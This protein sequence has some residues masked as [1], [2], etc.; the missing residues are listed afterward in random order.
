MFGTGSD[1]ATRISIKDGTGIANVVGRYGSLTFQA[2]VDGA[3]SGSLINFAIDGSEKVRIT[4]DGF[5]GIGVTN[6]ED[7]DS[8]A[9]NL[10]VGSTGQEGITIRSSSPNTGN[11]FFNDGLNL[12]AGISFKHDSTASSRYFSFS[13]NNG[14]SFTEQLRI[15]DGKLIFSNDQN[16]YITGGS[17][18]FRF[19]TGGTERVRINASGHV[20]LPDAAELQFGCLLYTSPSPRD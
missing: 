2:D 17:D 3:V 7:Y 6:P 18:V 20:K 11:L 19:T 16:S 1:A 5:V 4:S 10:V 9:K 13:I 12:I 15:Q 8:G 14:S